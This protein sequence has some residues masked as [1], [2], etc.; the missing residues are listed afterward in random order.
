M[1]SYPL[2]NCCYIP[3]DHSR[4]DGRPGFSSRVAS[5][6]WMSHPGWQ[7]I[8]GSYPRDCIV[9]HCNLVW[10]IQDEGLRSNMTDIKLGDPWD[11]PTIWR[12]SL[13]RPIA[14]PGWMSHPRWRAICGAYPRDC[15]VRHC[16]LVWRIQDEWY[17]SNMADK[18]LGNP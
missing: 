6:G 16:N 12:P 11:Y 9:R 18:G 3:L 15:I 7:A 14:S 2:C 1:A 17:K 8:C 13:P 10:G 4:Q 5:P